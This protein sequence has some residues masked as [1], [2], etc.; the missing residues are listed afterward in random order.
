MDSPSS[1]NGGVVENL[2]SL[3]TLTEEE[4]LDALKNRFNNDLIYVI[5]FFFF[6][7][8][9]IFFFHYNIDYYSLKKIDLC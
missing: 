6:F 3:T 1:L 7:L 5:S 4:I 8:P 2:V 9:I